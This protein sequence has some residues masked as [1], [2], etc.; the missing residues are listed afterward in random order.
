MKILLIHNFYQYFGGEDKVTLNEKEMLQEKGHQVIPFHVHN[1]SIKEYGFWDKVKF[2]PNM[3]NN[4][5]VLE[6]LLE[7][8]KEKSPD[9]AHIHNIYPLMSLKIYEM[10]YKTNIPIVQSFHDHRL[11]LLCPQGNAFRNGE[12]CTRCFNGNYLHCILNKCVKSSLALSCLYSFTIYLNKRGKITEKC[13]DSG[14]YFNNYMYNNLRKIGFPIAKLMRKPHFITEEIG[15]PSYK[16]SKYFIFIGAISR[17]KGIL[18]LINAF[19]MIDTDYHL[20]IL[21]DGDL[22]NEIQQIANNSKNIEYLGFVEGN[23]RIELMKNASCTISPSECFETFGL[24][25]LESL[26]CAV[27]VIAANVGG[28]P[29]LVVNGKTGLLFAPGNVEELRE[30]ILAIINRPEIAYEMGK[31]AFKMYI[32]NY[33]KEKNYEMLMDIYK[34]AIEHKK[35]NIEKSD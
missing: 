5:K 20:K 1:D 8:I 15:E 21:G 30:K 28:F 34:S 17:H 33:S 29:D 7:L 32:N 18:T 4:K 9:V 23:D 22:S 6:S 16:Y 11:S 10:L 25:V 3:L 19:K 27:P 2:F 12:M 14:I 13:I 31:N 35:Q 26:A 24:T